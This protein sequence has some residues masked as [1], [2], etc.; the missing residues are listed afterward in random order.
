[1]LQK[2]YGKDALKERTIHVVPVFLERLK[3][4]RRMQDQDTSCVDENFGN[5][6]FFVLVTVQV[7]SEALDLGKSS[8]HWILT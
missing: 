8:V 2:A 7:T 3:S 5:V 4:Q 6:H 1:M